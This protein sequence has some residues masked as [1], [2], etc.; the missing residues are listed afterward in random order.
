M[1][2]ETSTIQDIYSTVF[3]AQ[4]IQ[5]KREILKDFSSTAK[6]ILEMNPDAGENVNDVIINQMYKNDK[7][8]EF[9]TFYGWK[10]K[11]Y[12]V[13]PGSKAFFIWSKPKSVK[14][15]NSESKEGK[16]E[17]TDEYKMFGLAFLFS[18][19]QVEPLKK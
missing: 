9:A 15:K 1:K 19:S 2:E 7:H 4:G 18:N 17:K 5:E 3:N 16:E 10:E 8:K 11:G 6:L 14:K 12:K 13:K